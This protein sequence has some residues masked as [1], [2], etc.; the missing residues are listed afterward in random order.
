VREGELQAGLIPS[1]DPRRRHESH[2]GR[3]GGFHCARELLQG[4]KEEDKNLFANNPL[5]FQQIA[6]KGF[7]RL[8]EIIEK[9]NL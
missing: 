7:Y 6:P 9:G 4:E 2:H 5:E 8:G 1:S 3:I